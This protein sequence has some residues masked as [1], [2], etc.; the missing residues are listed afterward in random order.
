MGQH[1][2]PGRLNA[3]VTTAA[4]AAGVVSAAAI[5]LPASATAAVVTPGAV[6]AQPDTAHAV[7]TAKV[8]P[9]AKA[10]TASVNDYVVRSGDYL[11]SIAARLCG[12]PS[13][14]T[15]LWAANKAEIPDP[16]LVY[17]GQEIDVACNAVAAL[18]TPPPEPQP[19]GSQPAYHSSRQE[20]QAPAQAASQVTVTG[21]SGGTLGCSGLEALWESAGG[22]PADATMAASIAMAESGGNQ[23]ALSPTDDYGY[24]QINASNG[25]LATF[26]AEGNA[27]AAIQLS[28]DG[29]N[30]DA[31]TTFTEGLY[32]GKC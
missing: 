16:D 26:N 22:N 15:S 18:V 23:Y 9:H 11:S 5:A 3:A 32:V 25:A 8:A 1:S 28:D 13:K 21:A 6:P 17:P 7:V 14:W 20:Q 31:W 29:T 30:W 24:W 19:A 10:H 2:K 4:T 12:S 27:R